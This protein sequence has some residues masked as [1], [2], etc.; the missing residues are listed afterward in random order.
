MDRFGKQSMYI[1]RKN[2]IN[3]Q[4][5]GVRAALYSTYSAVPKPTFFAKSI[6][7]SSV[8][9][10]MMSMGTW[11]NVRQCHAW[12]WNGKRREARDARETR[13]PREAREAREAREVREARE[14]R[15]P[16]ERQERQERGKRES[17]ERQERGKREARERQER[18]KREAREN[19]V[20]MSAGSLAA[21]SS[22]FI[23]PCELRGTRR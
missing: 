11:K 3:A 8:G 9:P 4:E 19:T 18:G 14:P 15:E 12:R 16:R 13:E 10:V 23:P 17:R 6:S 7:C 5:R 20:W 21:T 2:I 22:M 1:M